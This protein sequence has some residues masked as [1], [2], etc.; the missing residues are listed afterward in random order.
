[1][2]NFF[3]LLLLVTATLSFAQESTLLRLNY[4]KGDKYLMQMDMKQ[5]MGE[6]TMIMDMV[7]EMPIEVIDVSDEGVY[8]SELSF[9]S[10]KMNM[11]Q[12]GMKINYDS[13]LKEE[14][15]DETAKLMS[16]QMKPMLETVLS[17][18]T[19]VYGE[20]LEMKMVKGSGNVDQFTSQTESVVYPKE[21]VTTGYSWVAE[22][23]SNG[24]KIKSIYTVKFIDD[25]EVV[26]DV[27]GDIS[28]S[29]TGSLTGVM[30]IDKVSGVPTIS[31]INMDFEIMG[32]KVVTKIVMEMKKVE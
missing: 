16:V 6:G 19:N 27:K 10:I 7:I 14:D 2:K 23:D 5:N 13:N 22:K 15:L 30:N 11:E 1:M 4:N 26:L 32:Q 12:S 18:Q 28:G 24:M 25:K 17:T 20:V 8:N 3:T 21:A 29:S 9:K 31:N